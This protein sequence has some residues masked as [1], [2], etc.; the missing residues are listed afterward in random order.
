MTA[1]LDS[2]LL[3][4]ARSP[5]IYLHKVDPAHALAL[6]VKTQATAYRAA[7]FLDDRFLLGLA[8]GIWVPIGPLQAA[9]D[10]IDC[11]RPLHFIFHTGHVGSTL[12]SRLLD[13]LLA[14]VLPL[15]EPLPLRMLADIADTRGDFES[16]AALLV[17]LWSRG[18]THTE[19]V[20]L[21]ASSSAGRI[22]VPLLT[23]LPEARAVYLNLAIE[24]YL[25]TLLAGENSLRDL[26]GYA[27]QRGRRLQSRL[28]SPQAVPAIESAGELAAMSWLVETWAQR[29]AL[30]ALPT[31][32]LAVD[33]AGFLHDVPQGIAR[34][35]D[36]LGLS[37]A[38]SLLRDISRSQTLTRYSKA[39]EHSYDAQTRTDI[40]QESR[41]YNAG[42][43]ARGLAWLDA[44]ATVDAGVAAVLA[45][46][47]R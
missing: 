38:P 34:V 10:K 21:K 4:L 42:E 26:R 7:S 5:D 36:H 41:R 31:R 11:K 29:I 28:R 22:A 32:V 24:P 2:W 25:A 30:D 8:D 37:A 1:D 44:L 40:L 16:Y 18:Y 43:I 17:R 9:A 14:A 23:Q 6:L 12:V 20:V 45:A 15:R 47:G 19:A 35:V 39:P 33:F 46:A 13:D 3:L 27:A